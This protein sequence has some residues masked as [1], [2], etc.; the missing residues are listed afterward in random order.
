M[1]KIYR[2]VLK[3]HF[4]VRL[5]RSRVAHGL[6]Q[7]QMAEKLA[8]DDR[9]YIDLDHG[10]TCCSAVTLALFLVYVCNDVQEFLEELRRAFKTA[11]HQVA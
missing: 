6:T 11:F 4:H 3:E 10:K 7:A 2:S 5:V 8:M 9:S 1:R